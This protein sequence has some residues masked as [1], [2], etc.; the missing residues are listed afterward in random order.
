MPE[1]RTAR[2]NA[3][4]EI[5]SQRRTVR[6]TGVAPLK[7]HTWAVGLGTIPGSSA[8]S[9]RGPKVGRLRG[10]GGTVPLGAGDGYTE[11]SSRTL[12]LPDRTRSCHCDLHGVKETS[13]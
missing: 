5:G 6:A 7:G 10:R 9:L 8:H 11:K 3:R 12:F 13:L 1:L 4:L 2:E